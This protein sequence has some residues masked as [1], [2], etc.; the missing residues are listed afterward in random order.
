[1]L[2]PRERDFTV[3]FEFDKHNLTPEA[4]RV[5]DAAIAAAKAGGPAQITVI[6]NTDLAGT[7]SY[8][9]V[10]SARRA[11]AVR[12]YMV[13]HG[14]DGN[15]IDVRAM[16]ETAPAVRTANGVREPRN[17][18]V[19]II[20]RHP[21]SAPPPTSMVRP[22]MQPAGATMPPPPQSQQPAGQPTHL[23]N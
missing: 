17:R 18:R 20:I 1:M 22:P 16:G 14:I 23:T 9:Q 8:N 11:E 19:E 21:Y 4:R 12:R 3:Y 13:E 5:L 2:P 6:G 15:E 7:N 10:L